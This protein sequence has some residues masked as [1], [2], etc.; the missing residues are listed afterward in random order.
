MLEIRYEQVYDE[1]NTLVKNVLVLIFNGKI[2][3]AID[4]PANVSMTQDEA[5]AYLAGKLSG[6]L[7]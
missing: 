6:I 1:N 7:Y 3:N 5:D 2:C 4:F